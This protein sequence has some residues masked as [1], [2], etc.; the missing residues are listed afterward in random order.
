ML[1]IPGPPA[2][3]PFR[4]TKLLER[5]QAVEPGVNALDARFVHFVDLAQPLDPAQQ[6]VLGQL[7]TYGPRLAGGAG[8]GQGSH[9]AP[10]T[11]SAL[12]EQGD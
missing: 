12:V 6:A 11:I 1:Q 10:G 2:L 3:S 4:I 9:P 8:G 5:L 7:L